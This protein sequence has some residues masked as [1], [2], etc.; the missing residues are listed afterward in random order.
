[1]AY[2]PQNTVNAAQQNSQQ[3]AGSWIR[4]SPGVWRN[5]K[6]GAIKRSATNPGQAGSVQSGQNTKPP[7]SS[8]GSSTVT[9][10]TAETPTTPTTPQTGGGDPKEGAQSSADMMKTLFPDYASYQPSTSPFQAG[11]YQKQDYSSLYKNLT[12]TTPYSQNENY[13]KADVPFQVGSTFQGERGPYN[14]DSTYQQQVT[15]PFEVG[16]SYQQGAVPFQ[17]AGAEYQQTTQNPY[18]VSDTYQQ[19]DVYKGLGGEY[20]AAETPFVT[21]KEAP[22]LNKLTQSYLN[23]ETIDWRIKKAQEAAARQMAA[24][25]LSGSG[26]AIMKDVDLTNQITSDELDKARRLASQQMD[27]WQTQQQSNAEYG[28]KDKQLW[29]DIV[30]KNFDANQQAQQNWMA[31]KNANTSA[32]Q[33]DY[34]NWMNQLEQ[35]QAATQFDKSQWQA[36]KEFNAQNQQ[37]DYQN[38]MNQ[39]SQNTA[40]A[41]QALQNWQTQKQF[42]TQ[43][44]QQNLQ[45]WM[46]RQE[47]N[48]A[49]L[50]QNQDRTL[51]GQELEAQLQQ[52]DYNNWAN[53]VQYNDTANRADRAS[54][55]SAANDIASRLQNMQTNEQA[56]QDSQ[57]A[58]TWQRMMDLANLSLQASPSAQGYDATGQ[59]VS[60]DSSL[61]EKQAALRAK[62][63][64]KTY[65]AY[66]PGPSYQEPAVP[67]DN[68]GVD[69]IRALQGYG[70]DTNN[71]NFLTNLLSGFLGGL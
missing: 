7:P 38:W 31:Q 40:A 21:Q 5:T 51:K 10:G 58:A 71:N 34:Q 28:L 32:Q 53:Q 11:Q 60:N 41:Q 42:N 25:G 2:L 48:A 22:D 24:Q 62:D 27:R 16:N 68:S 9:P 17:K 65:P 35:N 46:R 15:N 67:Y 4:L 70:S 37:Q 49:T 13:Q 36:Q 55:W 23:N 47:A 6:T 52:Q 43:V 66:N 3:G 14:V 29:A 12:N 33:Q 19:Q 44:E 56:R 63:Y 20:K 69:M 61:A 39:V 30:G 54:W 26:A 45:D 57:S 59:L 50:G 18:Q 1:M 8:P 64:A